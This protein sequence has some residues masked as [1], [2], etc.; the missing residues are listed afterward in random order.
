M[1]AQQAISYAVT[2][3]TPNSAK[4][5]QGF[6]VSKHPKDTI[7]YATRFSAD[8]NVSK[9]ASHLQS[10][11]CGHTEVLMYKISAPCTQLQAALT[12]VANYALITSDRT[13][14]SENH[15]NALE[16]F[17]NKH[18]QGEIDAARQHVIDAGLCLIPN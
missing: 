17:I 1:Q 6:G 10:T 8:A 9:R 7:G 11:Q 18:Q 16:S 3:S 2:T 4:L 13:P 12:L 5:V 14:F 15:V